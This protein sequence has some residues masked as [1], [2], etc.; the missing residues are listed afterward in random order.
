MVCNPLDAITSKEVAEE[1]GL[2]NT[3]LV[4]A[5][6]VQDKHVLP[7]HQNQKVYRKTAVAHDMQTAIRMLTQTIAIA[8]SL[9]VGQ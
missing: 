6:L 8:T 3:R 5:K 2:N 4:A 7:P 9:G 1:K